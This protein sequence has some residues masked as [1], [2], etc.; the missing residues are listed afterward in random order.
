MTAIPLHNSGQADSD[1]TAKI[2]RAFR[3]LGLE[4]PIAFLELIEKCK[5]PEHKYYRDTFLPIKNNGLANVDGTV[6]V[7]VRAIVLSAIEE[8]GN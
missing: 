6:D 1:L 5:N 4:D 2:L 7:A 8:S 3:H